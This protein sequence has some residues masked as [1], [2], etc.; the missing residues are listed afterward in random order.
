MN[1]NE[2]KQAKTTGFT[3]NWPTFIRAIDDYCHGRI[4]EGKLAET[5]GVTRTEIVD[6]T[7][8]LWTMDEREKIKAALKKLEDCLYPCTDYPNDDFCFLPLL[9]CQ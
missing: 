9:P 5:L 4:S 6:L 1:E 2:T 3:I 8:R 7:Y